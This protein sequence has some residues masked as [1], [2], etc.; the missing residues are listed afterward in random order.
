[1]AQPPKTPAPPRRK[2]AARKT[3][4]TPPRKPAAPKAKAN[5]AGAAT[6]PKPA[7]VRKPLANLPR[8]TPPESSRQISRGLASLPR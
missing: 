6:T 7:A 3:T 8:F 5:D 4:R 1:M 2:P